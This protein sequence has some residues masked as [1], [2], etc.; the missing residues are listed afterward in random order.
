MFA[1]QFKIK[2]NM[3]I[4]V[5][6]V[7]VGEIVASDF[8]TA[9]VFRNYGIDFCCGGK[10]NLEESCR[11]NKIEFD[12]IVN[13]LQK[14]TLTPI[15]P[16]YDFQSW[17]AQFLCDYI[18]NTHH[19]YVVKTLPELIFY[20]QKIADVHGDNHPEL[21]EVADLYK[22]INDKLILHLEE[23]E[24]VLFP[25]IKI[26]VERQDNNALETVKS[27]ILQLTA[28]HEFVGNSMDKI[29]MLTSHYLVPEDACRTYQVTLS[30]L[31]QFEDDL[32]IH[33]HLENNVLFPKVL[34]NIP[35]ND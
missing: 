2:I 1:V 20:T 31:Q 15:A 23:E 30:L 17:E 34:K 7:S 21:I 19:K 33:V 12:D 10:Q 32:H 6:K 25:A 5:Y 18:V 22:Q 4:N 35:K 14:V 13:E 11:L 27:E 26:A 28:E 16:S 29:T 9:S 24:K 8:R 3:D